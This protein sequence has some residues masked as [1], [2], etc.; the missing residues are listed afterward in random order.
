MHETLHQNDV[1]HLVHDRI[2]SLYSTALE[3]R[4]NRAEHAAGTGIVRRTRSTIGRH[5]VSIGESVGGSR[6]THA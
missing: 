5:L 1:D 2:G 6:P 4:P 3:T